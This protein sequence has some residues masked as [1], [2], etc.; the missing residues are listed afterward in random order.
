LL[1]FLVYVLILAAA[2]AV[3]WWLPP[4]IAW[5][6]RRV[7]RAVAKVRATPVNRGKFERHI[8]R[9]A[10][11][12]RFSPDLKRSF[13]VVVIGLI[14]IGKVPTMLGW[15]DAQSQTSYAIL[16]GSGK[17]VILAVYEDK[18]FTAN[19]DDQRIHTVRMRQTADVKDVQVNVENLGQLESTHGFLTTVFSIGW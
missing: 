13:W 7:A 1:I 17:Q 8:F 9:G 19:I 6:G 10:F 15:W 3:L 11:D 4:G 16:P 12:Y 18:T 5:I 2:Y 14:L